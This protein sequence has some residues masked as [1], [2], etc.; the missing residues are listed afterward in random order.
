[1]G[2]TQGRILK[3]KDVILK[4]RIQLGTAQTS[5]K[6]AKSHSSALV[7]PQVRIVEKHPEFAVIEIT[8]SCGTKTHVKCEY[9]EIEQP[10]TGEK[11]AAVEQVAAQ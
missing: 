3:S 11:T 6:A 1:M 2:K 5:H 9:T 8:C 4:G 7:S 10:V